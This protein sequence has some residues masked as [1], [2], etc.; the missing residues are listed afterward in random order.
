MS[1]VEPWVGDDISALTLPSL[2]RTVCH[3]LTDVEIEPY[4]RTSTGRYSVGSLARCGV[5]RPLFTYHARVDTTHRLVVAALRHNPDSADLP[6]ERLAGR[7][8]WGGEMMWH[9]GHFMSESSHRWYP[10][11]QSRHEAKADGIV[12][13]ARVPM[14]QWMKDLL[15]LH[16]LLERVVLVRDRVM[17]IDELSIH[18]QASILGGGVRRE[19]YGDLLDRH[20]RAAVREFSDDGPKKIFVGRLHLSNERALVDGEE[21]IAAWTEA[22]GYTYVKPEVMPLLQQLV[23][24]RNV[25]RIIA[26]GGSFVHL[27]DHLGRS[28]ANVLLISRGDPDSFYHAESLRSKVRSLREHRPLAHR[29]DVV[30]SHTSDDGSQRWRVNY[31]MKALRSAIDEFD[32]R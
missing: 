22:L 14:P 23:L 28:R 8:L 10:L 16:G 5:P 1:Q 2:D 32:R 12:F 20:L 11:V 17:R 29:G 24:M 3:V 15:S 6:V 4:H 27:F 25:E 13:S 31:K 18:P 7:W 19:G 26:I 21:E 9:F 30:H